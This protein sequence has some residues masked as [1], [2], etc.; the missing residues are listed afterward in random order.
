MVPWKSTMGVL[1]GPWG[2][3]AVD[4]RIS[5]ISLTS[6]FAPTAKEGRRRGRERHTARQ[7]STRI[8]IHIAIIISAIDDASLWSGGEDGGGGPAFEVRGC[9]AGRGPGGAGPV[10]VGGDV[11]YGV[12][13]GWLAGNFG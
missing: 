4:A 2:V 5:T 11:C 9:E 12:A 7:R 13:L 1:Q 10:L 6:T 8:N 3:C